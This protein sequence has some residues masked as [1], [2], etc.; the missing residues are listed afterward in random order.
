MEKYGNKTPFMK[1]VHKNTGYIICGIV[2]AIAVPLYLNETNSQE[3]FEKWSCQDLQI[4]ILIYDED[5]YKK[6]YPDH[7][8]LTEKQH[9]RL[10]EIISEC[11]FV[12][13]HKFN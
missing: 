1:F 10:H 12:L 5:V 13:E 2:L 4:Y 9:I 8:H 3:F 6:D 7:K 11:D